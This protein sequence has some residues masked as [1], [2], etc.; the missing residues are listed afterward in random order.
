MDSLRGRSMIFN[1][2]PKD[3]H[4]EG[5]IAPLIFGF[6]VILMS[7]TF[8]VSDFSA[9]YIARRD[10]IADTEAAL[11]RAAEELD[12]ATYYRTVGPRKE[13]PIDCL[14]AEIRFRNEIPRSTIIRDFRC[15]G[16]QIAARVAESRELPFQ[17]KIF[18][19]TDFT[20]EIQ[21]AVISQY[22]RSN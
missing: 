19:I 22:D 14:R 3:E 16:R 15:D 1:V 20:N 13:V 7:A 10:L 9:L 4:D 17:L 11:Y 18:A 8:V 12:E 5:S 2:L 21:A 6:F